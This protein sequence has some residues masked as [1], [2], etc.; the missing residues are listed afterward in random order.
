[1]FGRLNFLNLVTGGGS[2][3]SSLP[4]RRAAAQSA[5]PEPPA[6]AQLHTAQEALDYFLPLVLDDNVP[7][8]AR[9]VLLDYAGGADAALDAG[10]L[11]GLVYLVLG[12]PQFHLA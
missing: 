10:T 9:Q 4:L 6:F 8:D 12:S 2:I 11:R 7:D 1:M 5:L 3:G